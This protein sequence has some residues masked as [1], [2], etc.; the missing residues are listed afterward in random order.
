MSDFYFRTWDANGVLTFGSND[1]L[2]RILGRIDVIGA[3]NNG[4]FNDPAMLNGDPF[5]FFFSDGTGSTWAAC[6][7]SASGQTVTWTFGGLNANQG[8]NNPS[9]FIL[10][11][12][13]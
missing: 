6:L 2:G 12:I 9:G 7:A 3:N 13:R 4:T 8:N 5:A 11:G 1:R 10:Y